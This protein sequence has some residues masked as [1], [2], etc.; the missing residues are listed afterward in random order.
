M[1]RAVILLAVAT[2]RV[3]SFHSGLFCRRRTSRLP[4]TSSSFGLNSSQRRTLRHLLYEQP[5]P[6]TEQ[7]PATTAATVSE[8][9]IRQ[10]SVKSGSSTA[11]VD[12]S[13]QIQASSAEKTPVSKETLIEGTTLGRQTPP[14]GRSRSDLPWGDLQEWAIRDK[15]SRFTVQVPVDDSMKCLILWRNLVNDTPELAG[16]PLPYLVERLSE[17]WTKEGSKYPVNLDYH[18]LPFLD[19][20]E[21][22]NSGGLTGNVYGVQGVADGTRIRTTPV[23]DVHVTIPKNFV[24]TADGSVIFELGRPIE[25]TL[26]QSYYSLDGLNTNQFIKGWQRDGKELAASMLSSSKSDLQLGVDNELL[27]LGGLTALVMGSALA[28][29]S[30][31]HHLTINVFWV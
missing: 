9:T 4:P 23:G 21:F 27:Q 7:S 17:M 16:Y 13:A 6:T 8:D 15:V 18:I 30:L 28:M 19:A 29:E 31:S 3:D 20:F 12:S 1:R 25:Q 10:N 11:E 5:S 14:Q 24:R 2:S 26:G 22:E